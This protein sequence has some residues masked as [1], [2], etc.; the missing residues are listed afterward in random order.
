MCQFGKRENTTYFH[1]T[2]GTL[3]SGHI[4][5]GYFHTHTNHNNETT[6]KRKQQQQKGLSF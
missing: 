6:T 4:Y 3:I 1:N 5:I 2:Y